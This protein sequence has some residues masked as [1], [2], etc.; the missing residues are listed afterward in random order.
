MTEMVQFTIGAEAS[1]TDGVCGVVSRVV[2][3]PLARAVTHLVVEPKHREGLGRLVPLGLVDVAG[4]D[5]TGRDTTGREIRL[6]CSLAEFDKLDLA[7]ETQFL[8]GHSG[9][10]A[11][12]PEQVL[13]WPYYPLGGIGVGGL[14]LGGPAAAVGAGPPTITYDTLPVGEVAVRRGDHVHATDGS[15]GRVQGL[16]IEPHSR[17]VTHVLLQEGHLWGRKEVAIPISAVADVAAGVQLR[18]S[19]QDVQDLP[20]VDVDLG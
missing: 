15:I 7:Q 12:G 18:I 10:A 19:K 16:V 9:Y 8:P 13:A 11:Y 3:D 4:R 14:G 17:H 20:A 6:R 1:C 2:V 5:T